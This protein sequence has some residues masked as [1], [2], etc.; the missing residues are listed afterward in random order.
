MQKQDFWVWKNCFS[1][2]KDMFYNVRSMFQHFDLNTEIRGCPV[3]MLK[4]LILPCTEVSI[5]LSLTLEK[6]T[7]PSLRRLKIF[8]ATVQLLVTSNL[9]S[10]DR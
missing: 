10:P 3:C 9:H 2:L 5:K 6:D 1:D 8:N 7:T 4:E